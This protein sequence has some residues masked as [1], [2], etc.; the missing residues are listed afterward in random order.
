VTHV[1]PIRSLAIVNR[2]EAAMRCIRAVKSLRLQEGSDLRV[3]ALY[4][5]ADRDASYVRHADEAVQLPARGSAVRAYLDHELLLETLRRVGAEAVWPGW[6][7]VAE[8]PAFADGLKAAGIRF[9]GPS[10]DTMRALGDKIASK[11]LAERCGV[12]VIAWSGGVVGDEA[13]AR[14]AAERLGYPVVLKASAGGGGRGIRVV[15][16]VEEIADAFRSARGE[17]EHAFGDGRLFCERLLRGGRHVEVQIAAD[18]QGNVIALGCRD[19]SVQRRHQKVME[20][21]PPPGLPASLLDA[22]RRAAVELAR[23][24]R[25]CGVGTVEFLVRTPDHYFLEMNPRLQVEHGIT[26]EITG[27]DLVQLQ[28]R[29]ARGEALPCL[30]PVERG[31]AIE[32]RVCAEDPDAGFLP[33]PGRIARFDPALGPRVRV[34][35][36]VVAGSAVPSEFDSLIAKVIASGDTRE[37]ARARLIDALRDLDLVVEGGSTNKGYLLEVLES[38]GFARGGVHT[39]W[40][41]EWNERKSGARPHAAEGLA[42]A[43]VL[44]YIEARDRLRESFYS[45]PESV[46]YDKIP[47]STGQEIDLCHAGHPYRLKVYASGAHEYRVEHQGRVASV[48]LTSVREHSA[49][50][51]VGDRSLRALHDVTEGNI[52]VELEGAVHNYGR[53]MAGQV[54]AAAP[55][56]V[57]AV[58]VAPG[59]RVEAGACLGVL[60]AMKMEIRCDAPVSGTVTEVRARAGQ[61][62]AAG[63]VLAVIDPGAQPQAHEP[64]AIPLKFPAERDPLAILFRDTDGA[65]GAPDLERAASCA[66][67][68]RRAAV[69]ALCQELRRI[70]LGYDVHPLR[71]AALLALLDAPLGGALPPELLG[72]L[73]GLAAELAVFADLEELFTPFPR[74]GEAGELDRSNDAWMRLFVRRMGARGAGVP[75]GYLSALK[76][77]LSRYDERL[78]RLEPGVDLERAVLRMFSAQR[79]SPTRTALVA[80]LLRR[81]MELAARGA[82]PGTPELRE[83]L[84]RIA[85]LR[86]QVPDSLADLALDADAAVVERAALEKDSGRTARTLERW[87]AAGPAPVLPPDDLLAAIA[88]APPRCQR[89][90]EGWLDEAPEDSRRRALGLAAY[91]RRLYAAPKPRAHRLGSAGRAHRVELEDGRVV[92]LQVVQAGALAAA[93]SSLCAALSDAGPA[94]G[95]AELL[96]SIPGG[97]DREALCAAAEQAARLHLRRGRLTLTLLSPRQSAWHETFEPA[98]EGAVRRRELFGVHPEAARRI[99]LERYRSFALERLPGP[100]GVYCFVGENREVPE[101]VRA[102]VLSDVV[103]PPQDREAGGTFTEVFERA[104]YEATRSLRSVLVA[105]DPARRLKWNRIVLFLAHPVEVA[106]ASVTALV[107]KLQPAARHLGLERVTVRARFAG[108]GGA[109]NPVEQEIV[110]SDRSGGRLDVTWREP[111]RTPLMPVT[112]YQRRVVAARRRGLVH[113]YE[114]IE[115]LAPREGR[116]VE[117]GGTSQTRASPLPPGTFEEHDLAEGGGASAVSVAGRAPGANQAGI[118]FGV[119]STPT[120]KVP[121]GMRRVLLLSDPTRDLG[122][123]AAPECDRIVAALDLAERLRIPVEWVAVSSGARIAMD[124]GT[125]NLDATARVVRRIV[126]FTQGGGTIHVIVAGVNVGAQSYWDALA[127]MLQHTRGILIMTPR[128]AMVLTGRAAL[129]ASG[130]VSAED[131]TSIG[132][133]ERVM[134]PNGQAQFYAESL[135]DAFRLL[136]EH[137]QYTYVVPGERG[138]RALVTGDPRGRDLLATPY[139]GDGFAT[140]GE[141]FDERTNPGRKRAFSMRALM[142]AVVDGDGGHLERWRNM[143]GGETAIV[144]DAHLGGHPICMVGVES[145]NVVRWRDRSPDGPAEYNGGTLFPRSSKKVARAINGASGNRPVVVLANLCGFDGSPESMRELQLEHGAEIARAVVNF[146]GKLLF[147]VVSR[148]HGGAYVVFSRA[149]NPGLRAMAVEGSYASVIGGGPAA[150]VVFPREV[151]RRASRDPRVRA[152]TARLSTPATA[153]ELDAVDRLLSEVRLEKQAELAGEFDRIHSVERALAVGSLEAIVPARAVREHLIRCLEVQP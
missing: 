83:T 12:P 126:T 87:L 47:A 145:R 152:A 79:P 148:Y 65:P 77:V 36:G 51:A 63:D 140:V 143:A 66:A 135:A 76:R 49:R 5:A 42:L 103:A 80:A 142:S 86:G 24:V 118:V 107:G 98:A 146:S 45:D 90:I 30:A 121:E 14:R 3:I 23:T 106:P 123:L 22:L 26:E 35:T 138:P 127:T 136:H 34:D 129:A 153:E 1:Q 141:L 29:I 40:L 104:F 64:A 133:Y 124:S 67:A 120:A 11:E 38:D 60:E 50:V 41:D 93:A 88:L 101:D 111:H 32:A 82:V 15:R 10:G 151:E 2:G 57:I 97:A 6:G 28:I 139:P 58:H 108:A 56:M 132:G 102:F 75:E 4:T 114:I 20:E 62:V 109:G 150:A 71:A 8:D 84:A 128:A 81:V 137:Y 78:A 122:A 48:R 33:S 119:I 69:S 25:Y 149:L 105:R 46:T 7:F 110:I 130:S 53:R 17:A 68:D 115:M 125:E 94:R 85:A 117:A 13:A 44:A 31:C 73:G 131:E 134:G 39:G 144:W 16:R 43:G 54:V 21:A 92:L 74:R 100:E 55:S 96:V 147:L 59:D 70:V 89:E 19:C 9:L 113:P 27:V 37:E 112:D 91:V 18:Q 72:E 116:P 52:R 61:Q 95:V 99:E